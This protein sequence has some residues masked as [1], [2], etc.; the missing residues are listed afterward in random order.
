MPQYQISTLDRPDS[1]YEELA[2]HRNPKHDIHCMCN[3]CFLTPVC[4]LVCKYEFRHAYG[5]T[6]H[7]TQYHNGRPS[8]ARAAIRSRVARREILPDGLG[9]LTKVF[10]GDEKRKINSQ[11]L[12]KFAR[13][14][15]DQLMLSRDTRGKRIKHSLH[16]ATLKALKEDQKEPFFL[17]MKVPGQYILPIYQMW[18]ISGVAPKDIAIAMIAYGLEHLA[19]EL[20][21]YPSF[22]EV[23]HNPGKKLQDP[24]PPSK[25]EPKVEKPRPKNDFF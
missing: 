12:S 1:Y 15:Q 22:P 16:A 8:P 13:H 19:Q 7:R 24:L 23:P 11:E 5:L 18:E 10:V 2:S 9:Y 20:K 21:Q 3:Q 17:Q 14:L 6:R 25:K 4:C